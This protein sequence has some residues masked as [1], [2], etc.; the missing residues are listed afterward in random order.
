MNII[1]QSLKRIKFNIMCRKYKQ[2]FCDWL[3]VKVRLPMTE[4]KYHYGELIKLLGEIDEND[5]ETFGNTL[6]SWQIIYWFYVFVFF[7]RKSR[8]FK[9]PKV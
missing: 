6:E 9:C 8:R 5:E 1:I 3:W 2:K 4:R 7:K